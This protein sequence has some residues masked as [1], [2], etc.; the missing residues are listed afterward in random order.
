MFS[1]VLKFY[2][3]S[4]PNVPTLSDV[5]PEGP[6]PPKY[7]FLSEPKNR[8]SGRACKII[9]KSDTNILKDDTNIL[10]D[11]TNILKDDTN[12]LKDDTNILKD[13]TNILK[14]DTKI[15][16]TYHLVGHAG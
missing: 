9:L 10:K 4:L 15:L 13:D 11:D 3:R 12:I 7:F 2:E 8:G 1:I 14:D 16:K 6:P 5:L